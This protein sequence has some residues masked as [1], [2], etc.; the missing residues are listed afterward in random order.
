MHC[1]GVGEGRGVS[2]LLCS[3]TRDCVAKTSMGQ[4]I[5]HIHQTRKGFFEWCL[6]F[7]CLSASYSE[8][9][10]STILG[11]CSALSQLALSALSGLFCSAPLYVHACRVCSGRHIYAGTYVHMPEWM[12]ILWIMVPNIFCLLPNCIPYKKFVCCPSAPSPPPQIQQ[13]YSC[14][15]M[16]VNCWL[17]AYRKSTAL[18]YTHQL[19][20]TT[21]DVC[22]S[23]LSPCRAWQST[24]AANWK[25]ELQT[26]LQSKVGSSLAPSLTI[27]EWCTTHTP[28]WHNWRFLPAKTAVGLNPLVSEGSK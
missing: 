8:Q 4:S 7:R 19:F 27:I 16:Q 20:I 25:K 18:I 21:L 11:V 14:K 12:V 24:K 6:C 28:W 5:M 15:H 26:E 1:T 3:M 13:L 17:Q 23:Q 2:N 22:Q 10:I 9:S